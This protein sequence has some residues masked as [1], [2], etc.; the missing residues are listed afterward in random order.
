MGAQ[1]LHSTTTGHF[2]CLAVGRRR[3]L[4]RT[5]WRSSR[6]WPPSMGLIGT[7]CASQTTP[8][9]QSLLSL[10]VQCLFDT[11]AL[12]LVLLAIH[13]NPGQMK[14]KDTQLDPNSY[15]ARYGN[16]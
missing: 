1:I 11:T 10:S 2:S 3:E 12:C 8:T 13:L 6:L 5:A 16:R 15:E 14:S 9:A 7:P 4:R